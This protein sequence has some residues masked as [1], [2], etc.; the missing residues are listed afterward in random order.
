MNRRGFVGIGCKRRPEPQ[1][2]ERP[3]SERQKKRHENRS[4]QDRTASTLHEMKAKIKEEIGTATKDT[5]LEVSAKAE[6]RL[7]KF[8][9]GSPV[10]KKAVGE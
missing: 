9:N 2:G 8:K 7:A 4:T 5:D 6:K 10:P 3:K 1:V